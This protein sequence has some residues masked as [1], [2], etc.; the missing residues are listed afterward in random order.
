MMPFLFSGS[1][2]R[3]LVLR[4]CGIVLMMLAMAPGAARAVSCTNV[5]PLQLGSSVTTLPD[6]TIGQP[7]HYVI[8]ATGGVPPYSYHSGSLP[9]GITLSTDGTLA[10]APS[11]LPYIAVFMASVRDHHGCT[12]QQTYRLTIIAPWQPAP[13]VRPVPPVPPKPA[14]PKPPLPPKPLSTLPLADT[15]AAPSSPESEMDTYMLS[16]AIFKDKDVLDELKQ[17]SADAAKA[18]GEA[19]A[20]EADDNGQGDPNDDTAPQ[21]DAAIED[22]AKAQFQR[23]LEPLLGVE[24]PGRE[25]F[26]AALDTRL[27]RFSEALIVAAASK[28]GRPAPTINASDCPPDWA[29]LAKQDDYLPRDPLPWKQLPQWL[30]SPALRNLLIDKAME[31]HS[32]LNPAAPKWSGKGC[33]C[34][35][36]L[37]GEVYGF[38]PFWHNQDQPVRL[39]FSLLSRIS[40]FALWYKDNGDLVEPAWNASPQTDFIVEA[41]QHRTALDFTIYH[42][43][44]QFLKTAGDD[45]IARST[46]RLATEAAD[47]IDT[48]LPDLASRSHAWVPGFARVERYGNGLT[49]YLDRIPDAKDP[50]RPAFIRYRDQQIQALIKEL[51][52]RSRPYVLNIV[53][54]DAD[55][56]APDA[57]WQVAEM[58][59]FVRQAEAPSSRGQYA[60][61]DSARYLS[62]TNLTVRYLLLLT[63]PTERSMR[64]VISTI[65]K[66]QSLEE[67]D[68]RMLLHRVVPIVSSG[69]HSEYELTEN[70]A[71]ASDNFGGTG[72]WAAPDMGQKSGPMIAGRI[73]AM[74]LARHLRTEKLNAWI[75]DYRWPLRMAAEGL[76][77]LWLIAFAFYRSSCRIRQVGLPYQLGLLLGAIA[78]LGLGALLLVGD[79]ALVQVR[80]GNALLGVLLVALIATIAYHMLKPRVENP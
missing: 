25:L 27:C 19:P 18:G 35:R 23:M 21:G 15:L 75:C 80:R 40:V 42:N 26:A 29:K 32:L 51:R 7:Y 43:D 1:S 46:T 63:Q 49:L 44:W 53:L 24:Y 67:V 10:G 8:R 39:D 9:P 34:V 41:Q 78:F 79:P 64:D 22:D 5:D 71:Y 73:R 54:R 74:F 3:K 70:L 62:N 50:L 60:A 77:L 76:L 47:F 12:A 33:G 57:S 31:S 17:M 69:A 59:Q 65:D 20:D 28:Q 13:P 11:S 52:Q 45:D 30:M 2:L 68:T 36:E 38:Y 61:G 66:D 55:L 56:T 37:T 58:N 6:G 48:P 72:F 4:C 16:D 14:P